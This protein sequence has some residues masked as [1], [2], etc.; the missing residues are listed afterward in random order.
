MDKLRPY[1]SALKKYHFW[2][3]LVV[4]L[5][6]ALFAWRSGTKTL[7]E[8]FAANS[9]QIEGAFGQVSGVRSNSP[10]PNDRFI[11]EKK[12]A[13]ARLREEVRKAWQLH[14]Q[15]QQQ[16]MVWPGDVLGAGFADEANRLG[17]DDDFSDQFLLRYM[18]YAQNIPLS[19]NEKYNLRRVEV[20]K[21]V[22]GEHDE[23]VLK[24]VLV[25]QEVTQLSTDYSYR[26]K[27]NSKQ[28][29]VAQENFW[30]Y[31]VML[32]A[33]NKVNEGVTEHYQAPIK[34]L[35]SISLAQAAVNA[36]NIDLP[37]AKAKAAGGRN[38]SKSD[39]VVP[40]P[41]DE[42]SVLLANRYIDPTT[43]KPLPTP[44][45]KEEYVLMPVLFEVVMDQRRLPD[46]L[47]SCA[48]CPLLF[49]TQ[50]VSFRDADNGGAGK[51]APGSG[52]G[53]SSSSSSSS[54]SSSGGGAGG[55]VQVG[56]DIGPFDANVVIWG[57]LHLFNPPDASLAPAATGEPAV[58]GE[59]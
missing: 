48:N 23:S 6:C 25:W 59:P 34:Q 36:P 28:V 7:A 12:E 33:I 4:V 47:V 53:G 5:G 56:V 38:E 58:A 42:S 19:W 35:V 27:P 2:L 52:G 10:H 16:V 31:Q 20:I 26:S 37:Y 46:L 22:D 14:Y 50:Y 44:S 57:Y 54:K 29:R 15:R 39:V 9:S 8:Q 24:G 55:G 1:L 41:S 11:E 21:G 45:G 32:D 13:T 51:G 3:L 49:N 40:K 30:I 17:R 18:Q 43:M